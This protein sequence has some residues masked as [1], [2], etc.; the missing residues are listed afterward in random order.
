VT[1]IVDRLE[2]RG[3]VERRPAPQDRRV[4]SLVVTGDGAR[5]AEEVWS[6][7]VGGA[8][9]LVSLSDREQ[10]SLLLLLRRL[11]QASGTVCWVGDCG[12]I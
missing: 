9:A 1:G 10:H 6:D 11:D 8:L 4:K 2:H 3:L 12:C 7:V 5:L